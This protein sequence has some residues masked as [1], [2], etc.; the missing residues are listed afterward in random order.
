MRFVRLF[1]RGRWATHSPCTL[2]PAALVPF[3]SSFSYPRRT[4]YLLELLCA[5]L[6]PAMLVPARAPTCSGASVPASSSYLLSAHTCLCSYLLEPFLRAVLVPA[7]A[8]TCSRLLPACTRTSPRSYLLGFVLAQVCTCRACT[9]SGLYLPHS[10]LLG[11]VHACARTCLGSYPL[12][13]VP[14]C[15]AYPRSSPSRSARAHSL[16]G[17]FIAARARTCSARSTR[18]KRGGDSGCHRDVAMATAA[19][20]RRGRGRRKWWWW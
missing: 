8:R 20:W 14:A 6:A 7:H 17:S 5:A 4:W 1:V 15:A 19:R 10:Y 9:C 16:L 11:L 12:V 13:L 2:A 18:R 3:C